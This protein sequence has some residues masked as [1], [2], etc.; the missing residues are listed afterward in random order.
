MRYNFAALVA[1]ARMAMGAEEAIGIP[2]C[3]NQ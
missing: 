2:E 3:R 1:E